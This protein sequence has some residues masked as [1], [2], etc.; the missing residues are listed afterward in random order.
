MHDAVA[1]YN[2]ALDFTTISSLGVAQGD[3]PSLRWR[4]QKALCVESN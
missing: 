3:F 1:P 2:M 4:T